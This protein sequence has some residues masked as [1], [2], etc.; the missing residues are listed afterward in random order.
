MRNVDEVT[1]FSMR[2]KMACGHFGSR[3]ASILFAL[4]HHPCLL[5]KSCRSLM[6]WMEFR[7]QSP[8][9]HQIFKNCV[10]C[11]ECH[12]HQVVKHKGQSS[13]PLPSLA[14]WKVLR[15]WSGFFRKKRM[16][17]LNHFCTIHLLRKKQKKPRVSLNG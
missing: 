3:Q 16:R 14:S 2:V 4:P 5:R 1:S 9:T 17:I 10:V 12:C 8:L 11:W 15:C 13:F 6:N 7:I